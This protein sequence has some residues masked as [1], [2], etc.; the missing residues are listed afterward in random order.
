MRVKWSAALV[1]IS[2]LGGD[3]EAS[4]CSE[5]IRR[6][7]WVLVQTLITS[8]T[9]III[10]RVWLVLLQVMS[11][12]RLLSL[13]CWFALSLFLSVSIFTQHFI[14]GTQVCFQ[15]PHWTH[16]SHS[17]F[18]GGLWSRHCCSPRNLG[19]CGLW[20]CPGERFQAP[21]SFKILL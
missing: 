9:I 20:T 21:P 18:P 5:E 12:I 14:Q 11:E 4:Q 1:A 17:T 8:H 19:L 15:K 3:C 7:R 16:S 13:N 6:T 2:M 10:Y